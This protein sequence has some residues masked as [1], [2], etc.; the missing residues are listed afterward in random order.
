MFNMRRSVFT[1]I[2]HYVPPKIVKNTDLEKLMDTSDEWIQQRTG[3]RER[4]FV[5]EGMGNKEMAYEAA[6]MALKRAN[7]RAK[8]I[9]LIILAT[10]NPDYAFPGDACFLQGE[11]GIPGV[12]SLDIR[13]QCTGFVYGISI[14]DQF[15]RSG[16]YQRILVVG[17]EVQSTGL[18]FSTKGRDVSVIFADGA[19]AALLEA[20][21]Y[22]GGEKRPRGILSTH[23][24]ADGKYAKELW[25]EAPSARHH[26]RIS[27]ELIDSGRI[28]PQMNGRAVFA[29]AIKKF[30][31]VIHEALEANQVTAEEINLF[32]FHQANLRI[33]QA[34]TKAMGVPIEKTFN[35]IEKYGNTTA[36]SIPIALSEAFQEGRIK[37]N[38][39]VCLS[40]FGS[41]FTWGSA[42]IRW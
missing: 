1:G 33:V 21:E 26:P 20:V 15:I 16:M 5:E 36:A 37:K 39:L 34:V 38:D 10:L 14:A 11:L 30:Q 27:H 2:G 40:A 29:V 31:E 8:E 32:V 42:L 12:A 17:T 6:Q 41:G 7:R 28:Y 23:L 9:D 4:R 13:Q 18:D 35:N 19:G 25:L 22:E 24:H 3:I